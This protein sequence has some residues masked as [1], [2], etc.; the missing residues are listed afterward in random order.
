M[1]SLSDRITLM[2]LVDEAVAAGA[3]QARACEELGISARTLQRWRD[4][5]GDRRP[6]AE[7]PAPRNRLSDAERAELLAIANTPAYA[8]L[9]PHQIVP[10]LADSGRYVA[11]ESTLYRVLKAAGQQQHRGRSR[12]PNARVVTTH[13]A[14]GPN[15][16]WCWDITWLPTTVRGQFYYWYMMKDVHSRKLVANEVHVEESAEHAADLLARGCLREGL[17]GKPLVLHADNGS[18]MKGATMLAAM[19]NLGVMPSF[20]RPRVSNDNA[21]AE[22][23]FRTAK[24]CPLWP[25]KPFESLNAARAW[26]HRFVAWYN[27]EHRHSGL[28]YVT[29]SQRHRG[30][31]DQLLQDRI[32]VYTAARAK[33][34]ERWSGPIRNWSLDS[35][36]W[37]NPET[38]SASSTNLKVA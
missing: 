21:H 29:P 1:T 12:R 28:R 33:H 19:Q 24:Y 6:V 36:V 22:T 18:A 17:A 10:R 31:A 4:G 27:T 8:S 38:D 20:S 11:S 2:T 37:L 30:E 13:R 25:Q 34:P 14:D 3:R 5:A 16:L 9:P 23:V 15:Q 35:V 32:R 7:R 26:V